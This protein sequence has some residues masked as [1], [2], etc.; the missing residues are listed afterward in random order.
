M[1]VL[2]EC[3]VCR[4]KQ[5]IRNKVCKCGQNLDKAKRSK[6][7]KYWIQYRLP[8]G[9]QRKESVASFEGLDPYSITDAKD[10]ESKRKV[11][12]RENRIFDMLPEA[13]MTFSELAEW[14]LNLKS[15]KKKASYK[16]DEQCLK[17]FNK[18]FGNYL[19][20]S[21]K[22]VDLEDY[23]EQREQ[24]GLAPA[25]ID[26]EISI[27]K[28]MVIKAFDN[29]MVD[30]RTV[31]AFRRVKRKL[32][33]AANARKR[34]LTIEEYVK[35]T[36]GKYQ[37]KKGKTKDVTLPHL[38]AFIVVGLHTGMRLGELRKLQWSYVDRDKWVIRLPA[39][40]SKERRSKNIPINSHVKAVLESLPRA[41]H[42]DFVL[43]YKGQPIRD[44]GGLKRSF[45]TACKNGEIP[46]GRKVPNGITFHDIRRTVKTNMVNAGVDRVHRDVI[47]GHSL[48]GMDA[49]YMAPSEEDLHRAMDRY[50]AWLDEEIEAA[51]AKIES[52]TEKKTK[53]G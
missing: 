12:K 39:E 1:A 34:T 35:L 48:Q 14:Y 3:P 47:L 4:R 19:V 46:C 37:D 28:T 10:A 36:S 30:G 11:Q 52:E 18:V 22:P 20:G 49:H 2:G 51:R 33:K 23:Q 24:K 21:I 13:T 7:V 15:V 9:R 53:V 27:T 41:L 38:R 16:R 44:K 6:K 31:K 43:T 50:T 26:M 40:I 17:N 29:D 8:G 45:G 32:K 25:T 42:H 5:A